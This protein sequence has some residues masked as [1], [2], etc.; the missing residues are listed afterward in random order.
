MRILVTGGGTGGHT[1]PATAIIEELQRRDPRLAVLWVGR[2][3]AI[4]SR[5]AASLTIPFRGL[6]VEGWPRR[7]TPRR[8]WV[9]LKLLWAGAKSWL[10]IRKFKPQ[11]VLGVGGYVSLPVMWVAQR[12]GIPTVLHEQNRLLGVTNRILAQKAT[13]IFLSFAETQGEYPKDRARVVGNPVRAAFASPRSQ[14]EAREAFGLDPSIPVVLVSGGSQG[15]HSINAAMAQVVRGFRADE[16]QFIWMTGASGAAA[17]HEA[18]SAAAATVKVFPFIDDMAGACAAA[19]VI[20]SR[21]GASSTA[22]IAMMH[23]PSILIPYPHAT[24]RHQDHNAKAFDEAGAAVVLP[25]EECT[26]ERLESCLRSLLGDREYLNAMA[27]AAA[28]LARPAAAENVA[29]EILGIVFERT[30]PL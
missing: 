20:V 10:Y 16:A 30:P 4:E 21:A 27:A 24:D 14:A 18:S 19:D 7:R 17:A 11:A 22:E 12:M 25:D 28:S 23:K 9:A 5:V 15:A 1:S 26:G 3:G 2:T 29:E 6:A 13:R 8:A